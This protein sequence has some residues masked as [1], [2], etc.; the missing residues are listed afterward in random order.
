MLV[1]FFEAANDGLSF[2]F[3]LFLAL[4]LHDSFEGCTLSLEFLVN[5]IWLLIL[6]SIWVVVEVEKELLFVLLLLVDLVLLRLFEFEVLVFI[7][8]EFAVLIS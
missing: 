6:L 4:V 5:D 2:V 7:E 8:G 1:E 3:E